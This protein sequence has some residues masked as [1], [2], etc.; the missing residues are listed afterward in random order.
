MV[1]RCTAKLLVFLGVRAGSLPIQESSSN[2]WYANLIRIDRRR[3]LL[4]VHA[5]T[6][7]SVFATGVRKAELTPVGS[8]VARLIRHE[9]P[10]EGLA[11]D[12]LGDVDEEMVQL[13]TTAS[14]STLGYMN[15]MARFFRFGVELGGGL[16]ACDVGALSRDA[17]REL[18]LMQ[19][20]P[21]Y[22]V[23]IERARTWIAPAALPPRRGDGRLLDL[24]PRLL[25]M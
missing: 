6:L 2:D 7:F 25:R 9:L 13:A 10:I 20:P 16:E 18:H 4:V 21:G 23:P 19:T 24:K 3:C 8:V 22:L 11:A 15:E 17:R 5:G 14:R 1:L 12:A